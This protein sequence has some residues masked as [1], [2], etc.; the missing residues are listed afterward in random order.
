[1][2]DPLTLLREF[3]IAKKPVILS[4]DDLVFDG[5]RFPRSVD[6][7]F[8]SLRGRGPPYPL[9]ACWFMLLN[10]DKKHA[11]YLME[12]NKRKFSKISLVDKKDLV[13][14]LTGRIQTCPSINTDLAFGPAAVAAPSSASDEAA[15]SSSFSTA[16]GE[17]KRDASVLLPSTDA[18]HG[19]LTANKAAKRMKLEVLPPQDLQLDEELQRS[20]RLVARHLEQPKVR[21][22]AISAIS[23]PS[24]ELLGSGMTTDKLMEIKTKLL[25]NRRTKIE[26]DEEDIEEKIKQD[27]PSYVEADASVTQSIVNRERIIRN[28]STILQSD[29][30]RFTDLIQFA[31]EFFQKERERKKAKQHRKVQQIKTSTHDRYNINESQFWKAKLGPE[32][33]ADWNI[34]T[35]G[36]FTGPTG[37]LSMEALRLKGAE[38]I[39]KGKEA[40]GSKEKANEQE[41]H[42]GIAK[43]AE[44]E[45]RG[46][47]VAAQDQERAVSV[48]SGT[49]SGLTTHSTSTPHKRAPI[50]IIPSALTSLL[51]VY[52]VREFLEQGVFVPSVDK[53]QQGES[54]ECPKIVHRPKSATRYD[55]PTVF[56]VT[57]NPSKLS[58]SDWNRVVAVFALGPAW[59]FKSW[60]WSDPVELFANVRGFYLGFEDSQVPPS[61]KSWNVKILKISKH[62]RHLDSTAYLSFWNELETWLQSKK[63]R[64]LSH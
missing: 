6:T 10:Q 4:G 59:Q 44:H 50:I 40:E 5:V 26:G 20:K 17:L 61:V 35:T 16:K 52:N 34:N 3:T 29:T 62:K 21:A 31:T 28:R 13:D 1:M 18:P 51:T 8:N 12:A 36:S 42:K 48:P 46:K 57:D 25:K 33:A 22:S 24:P 60:K 55:L 63:A 32:N 15:S 58:T 19:A 53:K 23:E 54:R 41:K 45:R 43:P 2:A 30:K 56:H 49:E 11:D 7:N 38:E 9:D 37:G 39:E 14:Y 64:Q 47:L 27:K